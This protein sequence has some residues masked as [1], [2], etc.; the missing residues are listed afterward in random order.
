MTC[1][2]G[3]VIGIERYGIMAVFS[4]ANGRSQLLKIGSWA[5]GCA[6]C[7]LFFQCHMQKPYELVQMG[8]KA[9][10]FVDK[11]IRETCGYGFK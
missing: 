5:K 2:V 8:W 4:S 7:R 10:E 11:I 3:V 6:F 9:N 1:I